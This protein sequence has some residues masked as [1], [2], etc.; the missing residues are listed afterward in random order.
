MNIMS[1]IEERIVLDMMEHADALFLERLNFLKEEQDLD[2][3]CWLLMHGIIPSPYEE[4]N[5]EK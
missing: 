3:A 4:F 2:D 1:I 5:E